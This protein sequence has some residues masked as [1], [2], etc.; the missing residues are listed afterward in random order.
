[1]QQRGR[2]AYGDMVVCYEGSR[3]AEREWRAEGIL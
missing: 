1:M 3:W 2:K